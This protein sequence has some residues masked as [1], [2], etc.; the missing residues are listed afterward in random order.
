MFLRYRASQK[1]MNRWP[2][3][4][5]TLLLTTL[6]VTQD[7]AF[8]VDSKKAQSAASTPVQVMILG[9]YHFDSP[10]LDVVNMATDDVTS[11]RRQK[12]LAQL[13]E[14]LAR[15]A[16]TKVMVEM[17]PATDSATI[18]AYEKFT[19]ADLLK[20]KNEITQIGFR[21]AHRMKHKAVYAIDEQSETV[22][23]FPFK[24][25]QA[26]AKAQNV[27]PALNALVEMWQSKAKVMEADQKV[28]TIGQMLR[29]MNE[30]GS[31]L[32]DQMQYSA[33]LQFGGG[34]DWPGAELNAAWFLR[35]AKIQSKLMKLAEPGD[36]IVVVYGGG[37][38]YALREWVKT[39]CGYQL[40]EPN[41]YLR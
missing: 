33:L 15:F 26:Y 28:K 7:A 30:P 36:R 6:A 13:T 24:K 16:P 22:D 10:G 27:E 9:T 40:V 25:L 35:N 38:S 5:A 31:I 14:Q 3:L 8:A 32:R 41:K 21:L 2:S 1:M 11:P 39:T 18:P 4:V 37:H 20:D 23:Y 12:E 29:S 19:S 34:T 17:Q